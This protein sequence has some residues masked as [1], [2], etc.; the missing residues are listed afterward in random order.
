MPAETRLCVSLSTFLSS[1]AVLTP[2]LCVGYN[3][4]L[5]DVLAG[6]D[7]FDGEAA[8]ERFVGD[9]DRLEAGGY[10]RFEGE[11]G[12]FTMFVVYIV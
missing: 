1:N 7:R 10:K 11:A 2:L 3:I 4:V 5:L 8:G 12:E 9:G 6:A